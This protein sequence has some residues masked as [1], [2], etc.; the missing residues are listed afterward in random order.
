MDW[1]KTIAGAV[2]GGVI[3]GPPGAIAGAAIGTSAEALTQTEKA[4]AAQNKKYAGMTKKA[5]KAAIAQEKKTALQMQFS[6]AEQ[7]RQNLIDLVE[8]RQT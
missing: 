7:Q 6:S 5:K 2:I 3:G 4:Q 1:F 8:K